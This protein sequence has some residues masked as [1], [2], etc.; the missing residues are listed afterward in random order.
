V[1]FRHLR[2]YEKGHKNKQQNHSHNITSYNKRRLHCSRY[3]HDSQ[4]SHK[5]KKISIPF[6]SWSG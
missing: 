2:E 3:D 1:S 5:L 4:S 6:G